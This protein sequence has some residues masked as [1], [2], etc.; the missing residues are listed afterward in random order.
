M[1]RVNNNLGHGHANEVCWV[2][3]MVEVRK[4]GV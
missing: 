1:D 4:K 2:S 3:R